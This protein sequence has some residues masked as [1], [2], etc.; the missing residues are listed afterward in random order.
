MGICSG[1]E[2][3]DPLAKGNFVGTDNTLDKG[4]HEEPPV[5][6]ASSPWVTSAR[7]S[8]P[9]ATPMPP[10]VPVSLQAHCATQ[11]LQDNFPFGL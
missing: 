1:L 7:G 9:G 10:P 4:G 8:L 2:Q 3:Q 11:R 6:W 5:A